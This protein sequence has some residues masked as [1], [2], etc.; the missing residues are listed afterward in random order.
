[1]VYSFSKILAL[2]RVNL[3]GENKVM[4]NK[5][6]ENGKAILTCIGLKRTTIGWI[7]SD[8]PD[9]TKGRSDSHDFDNKK[10]LPPSNSEFKRFVGNRVKKV[11][12]RTDKKRCL[13]MV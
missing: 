7:F 13:L 1:M 9:P 5:A 10:E 12:K 6:N 4:C 11:F 8:E 3:K 2:N